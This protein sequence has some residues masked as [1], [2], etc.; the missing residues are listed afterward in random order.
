MKSALLLHHLDDAVYIE[1]KW[2]K[3]LP[4]IYSHET[5]FSF[6]INKYPIQNFY[7]LHKCENLWVKVE[8]ILAYWYKNSD[9]I[10]KTIFNGI[11]WA[12]VVNPSL[13]I[14]LPALFREYLN[15]KELVNSYDLVYVSK[16]E[17]IFFLGLIEP[18]RKKIQVYDPGHN[19][20]SLTSSIN[21]R[22]PQSY[23]KISIAS[24]LLYFLQRLFINKLVK[25]DMFMSC[26]TT[27]DLIKERKNAIILNGGVNIF[28]SAYTS[29]LWVKKDFAPSLNFIEGAINHKII[30]DIVLSD[31]F[32]F[33]DI[34]LN[35]IYKLIAHV[36]LENM[37]HYSTTYTRFLNL[38]E[39]Y[40]PKSIVLSGVY[41]D[42]YQI[43]AQLAKLKS[44]KAIYCQDGISSTVCG[45]VKKRGVLINPFQKPE[46]NC[47]DIILANGLSNYKYLIDDGVPELNLRLIKP[48]LL[49]KYSKGSFHQND[50]FQAMI[51]SYV[52]MDWNPDGFHGSKV[53]SLI[54]AIQAAR[55]ANLVSIA[56]KAKHSSEV[57]WIREALKYSNDFEG[58]QILVEPLYKCIKKAD[59]II[60]GFSTAIF[61]A[62]YNKVPYIVFEPHDNGYSDTCLK[63]SNIIDPKIV[64][65]DAA[66]LTKFVVDKRNSIVGEYEFMFYGESI[67]SA[68]I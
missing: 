30:R 63:N 24:S 8:K 31:D 57:K 36:Y 68:D 14:A 43:A 18:F 15:I 49:H 61:E 66:T 62:H 42:G 40:K 38:Y 54:T 67:V 41:F 34:F 16:N 47:F 7:T 65:R 11:S 56:V 3:D 23:P 4:D 25:K 1:N 51:M 28:K 2:G 19:N 22:K 21:L 13:M 27:K 29:S 17:P 50:R 45:A 46:E 64:A 59:L 35:S 12:R 33:D 39:S 9:G 5:H 37:E 55:D 26:W 60:G 20:T 53:S 32:E 44:I 58:V 48:S 52:P 6:F 10:D